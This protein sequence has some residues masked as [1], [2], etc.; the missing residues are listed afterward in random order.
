MN[1]TEVRTPNITFIFQSSAASLPETTVIT[2]DVSTREINLGLSPGYKFDLNCYSYAVN[3]TFQNN[4]RE[5]KKTKERC[6]S[7]ISPGFMIVYGVVLVLI[8]LVITCFV[9]SS[10]QKKVCL[11]VCICGHG[12]W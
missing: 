5:F 10:R 9:I 4:A 12:L 8:A 1:M 3:V 11:D 7:F 6:Y 2:K